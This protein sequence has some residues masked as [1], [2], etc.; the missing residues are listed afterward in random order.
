MTVAEEQRIEWLRRNYAAYS[1]CDFD[2]AIERLHPDVILV[3][4][5]GQGELRGRAAVRAWMEPDAFESQ[6]L[7]PLG[8]HVVANR[9]LVHT[10]GRLRGAGS[11]IEMEAVTWTLWT[12]DDQ[13]MVTRLEVFLDHQEEQ[14]H[15]ALHAS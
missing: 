11:G 4:A 12:F 14:A 13:G 1:R 7:E 6:V 10:H 8:F 2:T 15:R 5:G 9:V 3:R